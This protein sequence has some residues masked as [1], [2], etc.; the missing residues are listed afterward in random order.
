MTENAIF[1]PAT[2]P[3]TIALL[4]LPQA[5]ILEVAS[6]LDPLRNANRQLGH[7]AYRWRVVTPDGAP[8]PLT[9]DL[10]LPSSGPLQAAI[11]AEA[12][13][14]IAGYRLDEVATRPLIRDL[15]RIAPRFQLVGG[16]D[17]APWV[18]ARAGL[19]DGYRATV[20]WEDQEDLAAR[21]PHV[22]VVPD[23]YVID[24]NRVTIGGAAPAQD[25]ML[26]L[27]R[28]RH[29]AGL[30]RQVALS[31]LTTVRPGA[32]PQLARPGTDPAIDPR[33]A[34]ASAR[35]E[36][37][38]DAPES[39]AETAASVGLSPRRME[40]LFRQAFGTTPG[41]HALTLRLTAA[42]KLLAETQH[43]LSEVALR[44]GFTSPATL[45]RAF[46]RAYGM[47][48]GAVRRT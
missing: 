11:G 8:A 48:P 35:M 42:R 18:L 29:G 12:L 21:H 41:A 17:A 24:R 34:R 36:A 2:A 23:R 22:D 14:V 30:A 33:V 43:P 6:A 9:C 13:I 46:R 27:I 25:F 45:S 26:H 31:F 7:Q 1:A 15:R 3:L 28:A 4:V 38:L 44:T 19:L 10:S 16:I 47:A 40:T 5:S 39:M 32:E 37:R 20:H